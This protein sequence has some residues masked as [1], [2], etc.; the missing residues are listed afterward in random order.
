MNKT[1]K[2]TISSMCLAIGVVLPQVTHF[3][4][5]F[6]SKLSLMHMP[7]YIAGLICGPLYGLFVGLF[8]PL[9][10]MLLFNMP[11]ALT[12]YSMMIEL[13]AYGLFS[14]LFI[15]IFNNKSNTL[16]IYL[17]L[18]SSMIMGKIIYGV[19]NALIF[20]SG[21]YS[22]ALWIS[23]AFINGI[24][25]IIIHLIIVPTICLLLKKRINY[26]K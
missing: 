10:S 2:L 15:K 4:P 25:G 14:G 12:L 8:C 17:S 20:K 22:I 19:C 21:E 23:A 16:N 9:F 7:V 24:F 5:E 26:N 11:K 6:A 1:Y 3:L 18:I 13:G